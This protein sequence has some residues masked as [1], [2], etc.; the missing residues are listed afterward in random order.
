MNS[1][2]CTFKIY[3]SMLKKKIHHHTLEK[4]TNDCLLSPVQTSN[5]PSWL[6]VLLFAYLNQDPKIQALW[7][8]NMSLEFLIFSFPLYRPLFFLERRR[9]KKKG[10][11]YCESIPWKRVCSLQPLELFASFLSLLY[12]W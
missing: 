5:F 2:V 1:L 11:L 6:T 8:V 3:F 9:R 7:L 4:L 12:F 10:H